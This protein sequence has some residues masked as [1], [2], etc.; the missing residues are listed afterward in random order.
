[1]VMVVMKVAPML[2]ME[3]IEGGARERIEGRI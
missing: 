3:K 1:M 2:E